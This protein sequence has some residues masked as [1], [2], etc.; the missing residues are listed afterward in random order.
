[1]KENNDVKVSEATRQYVHRAAKLS[2]SSV[3]F[4]KIL[5]PCALSILT[6]R[7]KILFNF[8]FTLIIVFS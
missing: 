8:M 7:V 4:Y 2:F 1:M 3:S 6:D 5:F